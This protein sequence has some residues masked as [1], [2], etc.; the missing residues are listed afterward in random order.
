[1]KSIRAANICQEA[2]SQ[3]HSSSD[4]NAERKHFP[5]SAGDKL[6][7]TKTGIADSH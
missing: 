4:L 6:S 1:M 7:V 3:Q 5:D 2:R